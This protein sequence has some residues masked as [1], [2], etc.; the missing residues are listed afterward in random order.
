LETKPLEPVTTFSIK[1]K[2]LLTLCLVSIF[3]WLP[4]YLY[5]RY[6]SR[7]QAFSLH[8]AYAADRLQQL[9][10][11]IAQHLQ[12]QETLDLYLKN[13]LKPNGETLHVLLSSGE[14]LWSSHPLTQ[15]NPLSLKEVQL[16]LRQ[17]AG[18]AIRQEG[19]EETYLYT[20]GTIPFY[21]DQQKLVVIRLGSVISSTVK[22]FQ[23]IFLFYHIWLVL[24][25]ITIVVII[26]SFYIR[27]QRPL[28]QLV[29]FAKQSLSK[30]E[31]PLPEKLM[32]RSD[33]LGY[34]SYATSQLSQTA[35]E[36]SK[37]ASCE[38]AIRQTLIQSLFVPLALLSQRQEILECNSYFRTSVDMDPL[39]ESSRFR[40]L[41]QS[42]EFMEAQKEALLSIK[43]QTFSLRL[44]WLRHK[45]TLQLCP[46]P[47]KDGQMYYALFVPGQHTLQHEEAKQLSFVLKEIYDVLASGVVQATNTQLVAP[48]L[49][50]EAQ[51][52]IGQ[53]ELL[54]NLDPAE[55]FYG[56]E[57][58]TLFENVERAATEFLHYHGVKVS[59]DKKPPKILIGDA[60]NRAEAILKLALTLCCKSML[61]LKQETK[62]LEISF[63]VEEAFV[64][65]GFLGLIHPPNAHLFDLYLASIGGFC[66]NTHH[67]VHGGNEKNKTSYLEHELWLHFRRA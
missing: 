17:K 30:E 42:P 52:L 64:R 21:K 31:N 61:D 46:L 35:Q 16:A 48:F 58:S 12:D 1:T 10:P 54:R 23:D 18:S 49:L 9:I 50:F 3:F 26:S 15:V 59:P 51:T 36:N 33:E 44:P 62:Q 41:I 29:L 22:I 66:T 27:F 38:E 8:R 19:K 56:I 55:H 60:Q 13:T 53:L 45:I 43:P 11:K 2:F 28:Q 47:Y 5:V 4:G 37:Q 6:K 32:R 65:V 63:I 14:I 7:D 39:N 57:F 24:C 67:T 40:M 25:F 20:T 34:L